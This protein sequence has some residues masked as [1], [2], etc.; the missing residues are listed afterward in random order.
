MTADVGATTPGPTHR[1]TTNLVLWSAAAVAWIATIVWAA[2][3]DMG[4]MP[5]TMEFG[6]ARFVGMWAVMMA[7]M[8][9]PSVSPFVGTYAR[10]VRTRRVPR[11][12]A[13]AVGYLGAWAATG[14]G[15]YLLARGF[16]SVASERAW[17]ARVIAPTAFAAAGLYQLTPLKRRCLSHCRSPIAHLFH[18]LSFRGVTRDLRAGFRHGLFCLGCCWALMVLLVAFGVMNLLAMVGV[19]L[20]IAV[21]K[22]WRHGEQ[23]ARAV[24]AAALIYAVVVAFAPRLAPGLDPDRT[25]PD[26]RVPMEMEMEME[27]EG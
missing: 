5:G 17:A 26:G 20:V 3:R 2:S 25:M 4:A 14:V 15:A 10:T 1:V 8:M 19:A 13:L 22:L 7:A 18:Y 23:F 16:G 27:M 11:L 21:E 12:F 24:G 6:F 9:L